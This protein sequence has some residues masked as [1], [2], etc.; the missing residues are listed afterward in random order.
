MA[1]LLGAIS[2]NTS[3]YFILKRLLGGE[4]KSIAVG[5]KVRIRYKNRYDEIIESKIPM[6]AFE[7]LTR[8][9]AYK[10]IPT[11]YQGFLNIKRK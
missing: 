4:N 6:A 5:K 8:S 7:Q 10:L 3:K 1:V 9:E 2:K 11:S